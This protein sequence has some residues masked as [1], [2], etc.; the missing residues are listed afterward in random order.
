MYRAPTELSWVKIRLGGAIRLGFGHL[1]FD[2]AYYGHY[3]GAANTASAYAGEDGGHVESTAVAAAPAAAPPVNMPRSWPPTPPP[4]SPAIELPMGPR[5]SL[6][7]TAPAMFP[8]TAPLM[9]WMIKGT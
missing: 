1:G 4:M 8:P 3:G 6:L 5:L 7:R 2:Q 9:S